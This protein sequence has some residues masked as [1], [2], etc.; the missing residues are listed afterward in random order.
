MIELFKFLSVNKKVGDKTVLLASHA[1]LSLQKVLFT[2]NELRN[3]LQKCLSLKTNQMMNYNIVQELYDVELFQLHISYG[4]LQLRDSTNDLND[5]YEFI[6]QT[7]HSHCVKY[8]PYTYFAFKILQTWMKKTSNNSF[9]SNNS[10]DVEEKLESIIFS[11]WDNSICKANIV[12]I[13]ASYLSIMEQKYE[14]YVAF[15]FDTC[16]K[17]ISWCH[18]TKYVILSEI[19]RALD[20]IELLTESNFI[21]NLFNSLTI[22]YLCS[23]SS[24]IYSNICKKL[25][26]DLWI[27][28]FGAHLN[29]YVV[30]WE[31]E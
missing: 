3:H 24:K 23:Y 13:F 8:T 18:V 28:T 1:Y 19:C 7:I 27:S 14:N 17:K 2:Q 6:F 5:I 22:S 10:V 15:L 31:A 21:S 4:F 29:N 16:I 20:N 11:N 9:W 25:T 26:K 30:T 12:E